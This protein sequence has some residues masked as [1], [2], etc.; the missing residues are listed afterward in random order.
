M[1]ILVVGDSFCVTDP[2]FPNLHWSEKLLNLSPEIELLN[3]AHG[4]CS[5][6]QRHQ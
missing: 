4:G 3:L 6:A 1:K 2:S 5:N